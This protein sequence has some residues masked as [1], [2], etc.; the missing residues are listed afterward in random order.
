M[1]FFFNQRQRLLREN[2]TASAL[3]EEIFAMMS[4]DTPMTTDNSVKVDLP[5]ESKVAPYQV[6]NYTL[7]DPVFSFTG[8]GGED[9]GTWAPSI[10]PINEIVQTGSGAG[11]GGGGVFT[12]SNQGKSYPGF[13]TG[14]SGDTY[15]V[16]IYKSGY[17][18]GAAT[19][20]TVKQLQISNDTI[21]PGTAAIVVQGPNNE[22]YMQVPVF[23]S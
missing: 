1:A 11:G 20:V 16:D 12:P 7:G 18:S 4:P 9:L 5:T 21:P 22:Y 14:G 19:N 6:G 15:Q 13:V 8:K 10:D 23:V 3:A 17:P 2:W